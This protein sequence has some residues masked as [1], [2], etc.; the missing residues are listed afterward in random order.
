LAEA[1]TGND[2]P[3][4]MYRFDWPTPAFGGRLGAC[5]AVEIPFVFDNLSAPGADAFL[6]GVA[7][8]DLATRVHSAWV[9]FMKSGDPGWDRYDSERRATMIFDSESKVVDDP[10]GET[11]ALWDG[12]L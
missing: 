7:P 11:R 8:Q 3:T 6:G 5:H 12:L 1:Q 10:D 4:W 2:T 9:S